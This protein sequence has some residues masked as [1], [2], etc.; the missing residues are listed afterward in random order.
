[1]ANQP[2][3]AGFRPSP[4]FCRW[5]FGAPRFVEKYVARGSPPTTNFR[6]KESN[7]FPL[8]V[9]LALLER[10]EERYRFSANCC[11]GLQGDGT[12]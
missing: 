5:P 3:I 1:M 7:N 8:P 12:A 6:A 2:R 10:G 11:H 9:N 4:F